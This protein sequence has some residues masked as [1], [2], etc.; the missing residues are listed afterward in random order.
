RPILPLRK[1]SRGLFLD[2]QLGIL[3]IR[4]RH[5]TSVLL[6]GMEQFPTCQ[7]GG[8]RSGSLTGA[9]SLLSPA[10][11]RAV[12]PRYH[13]YDP[14]VLQFQCAYLLYTAGT[15][16]PC[17]RSEY[18]FLA[19]MAA[20]IVP[21]LDLYRG[22]LYPVRRHR[23]GARPEIGRQDMADGPQRRLD[24]PGQEFASPN[25]RH[26]S[27]SPCDAHRLVDIPAIGYALRPQQYTRPTQ[28]LEDIRHY[29]DLQPRADHSALRLRGL[30]CRGLTA[31]DR[32]KPA[33]SAKG[34]GQGYQSGR[35]VRQ[36]GNQ[37]LQAFGVDRFSHLGDGLHDQFE[38][39]RSGICIGGTDMGSYRK[40]GFGF[41]PCRQCA[42]VHIR[43][44]RVQ[45]AAEIYRLPLRYQRRRAGSTGS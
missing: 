35:L 30:H 6:L 26:V 20:P 37:R 32:G 23:G 19:A 4:P 31:P 29:C 41:L 7:D 8:E 34:T 5:R 21:V 16:G 36:D 15:V 3:F 28:S 24:L 42:S 1:W 25:T 44:L 38:Y 9:A 22:V 12:R 10:P 39:L 43:A 11:A 14:S 27:L 13:P 33:A 18:T 40:A 45:P 17:D 2:A